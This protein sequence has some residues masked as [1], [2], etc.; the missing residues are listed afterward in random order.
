MICSCSSYQSGPREGD[1]FVLM[2][3][4]AEIH[5]CSG[6]LCLMKCHHQRGCHFA[7][8]SKNPVSS[9]RLLRIFKKDI[10]EKL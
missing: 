10:W 6:V 3:L 7:S 2:H 5:L 4:Q 9:C 8:L 1:G